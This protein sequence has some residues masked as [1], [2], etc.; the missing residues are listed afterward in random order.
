MSL[1][2][3]EIDMLTLIR[4]RMESILANYDRAYAVMDRLDLGRAHASLTAIQAEAGS[5]MDLID[6]AKKGES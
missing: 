4:K 1:E 5:V 6:L 3:C 2:K